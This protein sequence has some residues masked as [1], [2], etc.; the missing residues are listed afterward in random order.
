VRV[1]REQE[2]A[3]ETARR[4]RAD[5][6]AET[7]EGPFDPAALRRRAGFLDDIR[8]AEADAARRLDR[9]RREEAEAKRALTAR[10][11]PEEALRVLRD[12]EATAHHRTIADAEMAFLDEQAVAGHCRKQRAAHA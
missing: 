9:L 1:R 11:Q 8:R 4:R 10:R 5:A 7:P 12:H 2:D 6:C 3:L